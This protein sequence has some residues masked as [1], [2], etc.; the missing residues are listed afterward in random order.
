MK[1]LFSIFPLLLCVAHYVFSSEF[2]NDDKPRFTLLNGNDSINVFEKD[3]RLIPVFKQNITAGDNFYKFPQAS[4]DNLRHLATY[5]GLHKRVGDLD[6]NA[7]KELYTYTKQLSDDALCQLTNNV[8]KLLFRLPIFLQKCLVNRELS[9]RRD[10]QKGLLSKISDDLP[11]DSILF[12]CQEF[13]QKNTENKQWLSQSI[14]YNREEKSI[15]TCLFEP[16][17]KSL[18]QTKKLPALSKWSLLS[19]PVVKYIYVGDKITAALSGWAYASSPHYNYVLTLYTENGPKE[20]RLNKENLDFDDKGAFA[21]VDE[22]L[23]VCPFNDPY[24]SDKNGIVLIDPHNGLVSY[25]DCIGKTPTCFGSNDE[26]LSFDNQGKIFELSPQ[27]EWREKFDF[28]VPHIKGLVTDNEGGFFVW[29]R[30]NIFIKK[31]HNNEIEQI[32]VMP[33]DDNVSISDV[34][35]NSAGT[36]ICIKT[37][38]PGASSNEFFNKYYFCEENRLEEIAQ[39][40]TE[41]MSQAA[42]SADD[43]LL[44]ISSCSNDITTHTY[45]DL[46]CWL[47][48]GCLSSWRKETNAQLLAVGTGKSIEQKKDE[49]SAYIN[50]L[51]DS[52]MHQAL[53]SLTQ[54]KHKPLVRHPI[55]TTREL[56][57]HFSGGNP[58]EHLYAPAVKKILDLKFDNQAPVENVS[59]L[60]FFVALM[61]RNKIMLGGAGLL[62][63]IAAYA[64]KTVYQQSGL[65]F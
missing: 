54:E 9:L 8:Y 49:S 50:T 4:H 45:F 5:V 12:D 3:A 35:V 42:F 14:K 7:Q 34:I 11:K 43:K 46:G 60:R 57:T 56:I 26:L 38:V 36:R 2:E 20:F 1:K 65:P 37:F 59:A 48:D 51:V 21:R 40:Y 22:S 13:Y 53:K 55:E 23:F 29:D 39:Y 25:V 19:T 62:A 61:C 58:K 18:N 32:P 47:E 52:N 33:G 64:Y 24:E 6:R 41:E 27:H 17:T 16:Y 30:K 15:V 63:L 44:I 31:A 10:G 28:K